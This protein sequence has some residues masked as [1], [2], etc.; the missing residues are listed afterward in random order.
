M[1]FEG[2]HDSLLKNDAEAAQEIKIIRTTLIIIRLLVQTSPKISGNGS[3]W[4][5]L[6]DRAEAERSII[7]KLLDGKVLFT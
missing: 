3:A 1:S 7:H 4:R 6:A 2:Q 5:H